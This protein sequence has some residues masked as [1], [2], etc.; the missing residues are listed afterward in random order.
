MNKIKTE[1]CLIKKNSF[2]DLE[3]KNNKWWIDHLSFRSR[4][5]AKDFVKSNIGMIHI[6]MTLDPSPPIHYINL[7]GGFV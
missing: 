5:K 4:R 6:E 2:L 7:E 3:W 1:T